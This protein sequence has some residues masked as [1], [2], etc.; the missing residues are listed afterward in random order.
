MQIGSILRQNVIKGAIKVR[1]VGSYTKLQLEKMTKE[2]KAVLFIKGT[3]TEPMCG[4][5][6]S[7]IRVMQLHTNNGVKYIN[8]LQD[9]KLRQSMKDYSKWPTFPQVKKIWE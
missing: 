8:I 1:N 6:L 5:S 3:E 9:E 2:D 7:T 4:F